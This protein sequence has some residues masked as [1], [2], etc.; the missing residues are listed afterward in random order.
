MTVS[1]IF[2]HFFRFLSIAIS[3]LL[4]YPRTDTEAILDRSSKS[5][6]NQHLADQQAVKS[7][8]EKKRNNEIA[9]KQKELN[10]AKTES[11]DKYVQQELIKLSE[12]IDMIRD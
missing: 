2:C 10:T 3:I 5:K 12:G 4:L 11:I 7:A 1:T 9:L 8:W 6:V